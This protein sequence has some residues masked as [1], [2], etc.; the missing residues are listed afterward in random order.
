MKENNRKN[1]YGSISLQISAELTYTQ[2]K[3]RNGQAIQAE[4]CKAAELKIDPKFMNFED[5]HTNIF[6]QILDFQKGVNSMLR[7]IRELL[8]EGQYVEFTI[9]THGFEDVPEHEEYTAL[10]FHKTSMNPL[11]SNMWSYKGNGQDA[12]TSKDGGLYLSPD[13][14]YTDKRH[15]IWMEWRKDI[16]EILKEAGI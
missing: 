11:F 2:N 7:Q 13:T 4:V 12:D 10:G 3:H 9:C 8:M 5:S 14:R 6:G 15:D 1:K 16:F